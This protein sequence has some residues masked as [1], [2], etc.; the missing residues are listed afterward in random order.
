[1]FCWSS[2]KKKAAYPKLELFNKFI[3]LSCRAYDKNSKTYS[4]Y[5]QILNKN[6]E[7][8]Y[9]FNKIFSGMSM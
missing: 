8:P 9:D 3:L 7:I 6:V 4:C 5:S 1:M 2:S